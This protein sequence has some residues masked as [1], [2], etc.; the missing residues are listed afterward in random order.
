MEKQYVLALGLEDKF[1]VFIDGTIKSLNY[2]NSGKEKILDIKPR[3]D[4]YIR[5]QWREDGVLKR[6]YA[7]D[8]VWEAFNGSIPELHIVHHINHNRQDN[9]LDNLCLLSLSEHSSLHDKE[10][11]EDRKENLHKCASKNNSKP[12]LQFSMD[13][14]LIAEYSS[15]TEASKATGLHYSCIEYCCLGRPHHNSAGKCK[16]KFKLC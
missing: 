11:Y 9:R 7:H 10:Q 6:K 3:E 13:G 16:W 8:M 2:R 5:V 1:A 14:E 12:V 15:I 4:G